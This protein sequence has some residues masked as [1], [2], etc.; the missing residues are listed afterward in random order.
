MTITTSQR[1]LL[2]LV[3]LVIYFFAL[4]I[5]VIGQTEDAVALKAKARALIDSQKFTDALPLYERLAT[6]TPNDSEAHF[7]LAFSL[8]GQAL[9]SADTGEK[10][11]LRVRA[12]KEYL[13]A[14]ELG[15]NSELLKGLIESLPADGHLPAGFSDNAAANKLMDKGEA[16]FATGKLDE[17]LSHYQNA[18]KIDPLCYHAALF[19]GDVYVQQDKADDAE[20]WYKKAIAINP[21]VETAYRYSAT[22]LMKQKKY[23]LAKDRYIEA[24]IVEPYSKLAVSGIIQW[25]QATNTPLGH[26]KFDIPKITVGADGKVNSNVT[27][28]QNPADGSIAWMSY[29]TTREDWRKGKFAKAFPNEKQYRHSMKEEADALRSVVVMAKTLK[30]AKLNPQIAQLAQ[31]D[32]DGVLEAFVL[33]AIPDQGIAQDHPAYLRANRDKLRQYVL[34]Y[35]IAGK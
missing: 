28:G 34:K 29:V 24:F 9:T 25:G 32:Q 8:L 13:R 10:I 30:L 18:L 6:L 20:I 2:P 14:Q 22:P 7:Y 31:L 19:S 17:A 26:P 1:L 15:N 4:P 16:A 35:V 11:Q 27:V 12:R 3:L 23:D 33:M 5:L 21:F